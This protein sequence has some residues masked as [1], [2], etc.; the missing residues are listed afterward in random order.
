GNVDVAFSTAQRNLSFAGHG[1]VQIHAG[2]RISAARR[3]HFIPIA[4]LYNFHRKLLGKAPRGAFAPAF[5]IYFAGYANLWLIRTP[6]GDV[7]TVDADRDAG[8][9]RD[10]LWRD[11]QAGGKSVARKINPAP[12]GESLMR[13]FH[14]HDDSQQREQA[15]HKKN[16]S[17]GDA[18]RARLAC[19]RP[20]SPLV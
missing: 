18:R 6:Q 8:V 3:T 11:I 15:Q 2:S 17:C 20:E 16:F 13:L 14:A 4:V 7:A 9:R 12:I 10:C 19:T 1:D 5:D